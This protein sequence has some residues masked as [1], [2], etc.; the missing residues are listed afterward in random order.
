MNLETLNFDDPTVEETQEHQ[1]M[2]DEIMFQQK[3][4]ELAAE[5]L[6]RQMKL[7]YQ[8]FRSA[9]ERKKISLN[10]YLQ[11]DIKRQLLEQYFSGQFSPEKQDL[12]RHTIAQVGK[13]FASLYG[14][15]KGQ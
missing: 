13:V 14:Y 15:A 8:R 3:A 1:R 2:A 9:V 4:D 6:A 11:T 7:K 10:I 5:H 12:R